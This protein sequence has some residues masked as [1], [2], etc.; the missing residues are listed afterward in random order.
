SSM[1]T[2]KVS[3]LVAPRQ[4]VFCEERI[5]PDNLGCDEIFCQTLVSAISPGTEI[6]AY[7]GAPPL[8][9]TAQP[10]PR[11]VGYLNVA[12]V[13]AT[14]SAIRACTV[15][16]RI[17]TYMCHR[18]HFILSDDKVMAV[19][20]TSL[21]SSAATL[22]YLYRLALNGLRRGQ[23][24]S[25]FSVAV[26]GLGPIGLCAVQQASMLGADVTAVSTRPE[27]LALARRLGAASTLCPVGNDPDSVTQEAGLQELD[28]V[29]TTS[30]RWEDWQLA[31]RLPRFNGIIVVLGFPGR[32]Q[33]PSLFN[34]LASRYL[35]DHQLSI[36]GAGMSPAMPGSREADG[37]DAQRAD[38][39]E[40]LDQMVAGA[41]DASHL[42]DGVVDAEKLA[43]AYEA[44]SKCRS[45][46]GTLIL[47]W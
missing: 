39:R 18:S 12:R 42:I 10:Y 32:G 8:R 31:L 35:Y 33:P 24:Q 27:A 4:L 5:D 40:I 22:A 1:I 36:V 29:I 44:L 11:L 2:A 41:I 3:M 14:G 34:P 26:I 47:R 16:D 37:L 43:N 25:D 46:S 13:Q 28:L 17:L 45:G 23:V 15:G 19:L 21:D 30:N 9:P 20:P 7:D 38:L 6:A